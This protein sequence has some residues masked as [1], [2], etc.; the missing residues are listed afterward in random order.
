MHIIRSLEQLET[1]RQ[2]VVVAVGVFD[3]VH[4]GHQHV[5]N[6]CREQAANEQAEPW[7]M[8][9]DPHPL[10]VVQP[11]SAPLLL[12][13]LSAKLDLLASQKTAGCMVIPFTRAFS[14]IEPE[15]FLDQLVRRIPNLKGLVIGENW[16]FGRR[17]RGDVTLLHELS[18]KYHFHVSVAKPVFSG[19]STVSSSRIREAIAQGHLD[20]AAAMLGRSHSVRG[21]VVHGLKRGRRLGFPTANIDVKG[22]AVPPSGIYAAAVN[23]EER[24]HQGALYL[25]AHPEPH[26][27]NLEV[28][29]IDFQGDLYGKE[30]HVE[31]IRKIREDNLRFPNES[32]LIQQIRSDVSAIREIFT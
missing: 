23:L 14:E 4:L 2:P 21:I 16:R 31:I 17:A 1:I 11:A 15:V 29:L 32:D 5:I 22:F 30:L 12:T 8:T 13:S 24:T 20:T 6:L 25:P 7:V 28:H 9:F 26:H 18:K 3:G 10:K 27:G 19:G